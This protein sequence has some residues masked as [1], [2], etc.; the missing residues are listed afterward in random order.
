[1]FFATL[2]LLA[3]AYTSGAIAQTTG[4]NSLLDGDQYTDPT[5]PEEEAPDAVPKKNQSQQWISASR[6]IMCNSIPYIKGWLQAK[7]QVM[8]GSGHK[9]K[10]YMP[11]DP[12]DGIILLM[13][14]E[15]KEYTMLLVSAEHNLACITAAGA[16]FTTGGVK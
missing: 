5:V 7:G 14:L 10:E 11:S 12:F 4:P 1:M 9:P 3:V 13:N 6:P 15:T 8:I 2:I 16:S